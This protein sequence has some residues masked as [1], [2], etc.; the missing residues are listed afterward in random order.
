MKLVILYYQVKS[1]FERVMEIIKNIGNIVEKSAIKN[2][3]DYIYAEYKNILYEFNRYDQK[4]IE[5]IEKSFETNPYKHCP[6]YMIENSFN[7]IDMDDY[8]TNKKY[9]YTI[10]KIGRN[11]EH[12]EYLFGNEADADD[13]EVYILK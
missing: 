6:N 13:N 11:K 1:E 3:D 4:L 5:E 8:F 10:N 9:L 12:F 7:V 2:N